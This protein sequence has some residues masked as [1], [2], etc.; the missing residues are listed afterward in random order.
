[1]IKLSED[2]P[3]MLMDTKHWSQKSVMEVANFF[4]VDIKLGLGQQ[5]VLDRIKKFGLN[6]DP[7][8]SADIQDIYK[9]QVLRNGQHQLIKTR[10]IVP[11]DIV[12]IKQGNRVPADLRLFK[13]ANLKIDQ[14]ALTGD[15]L[16]SAKNT[17]SLKKSGSLANQKC[18]AFSGSYVDLGQGTG[19]VINQACAS[20]MARLYPKYKKKKKFL[21]SIV[22]RK[23][24]SAGL[25]VQNSKKVRRLSNFDTIVFNLDL[26]KQEIQNLIIKVQLTKNISC[27]FINQNSRNIEEGSQVLNLSEQKKLTNKQLFKKLQEHNFVNGV[28]ADD[29]V[30]ILNVLANNN[31]RALYVTDG[32]NKDMGLKAAYVSMLLGDYSRDDNI[33]MADLIAPSQRVF[34]IERI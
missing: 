30:R 18:I 11:G 28:K 8:I 23:L 9:T 29:T 19:I 6:S 13:V 20:E 27:K 15:S 22:N 21:S 10:N 26:T 24:K 2:I 34:I 1:M 5:S 32:I 14:S 16:P 31:I 4:D 7:T 17:Y 3:K 12:T 33:A 25:I